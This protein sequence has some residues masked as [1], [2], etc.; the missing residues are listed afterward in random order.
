MR[1][2]TGALLI[3]ILFLTGCGSSKSGIKKSNYDRHLITLEEIERTTGS[4]AYDL[5]LKLRPFWIRGRGPRSINRNTEA[6]YPMIYLN[7]QK[8][9][10]ID[11]LSEITNTNITEIKFLSPSD[12][13][14]RYGVN[15]GGGA[16]LIKI[17]YE[18]K[19]ASEQ[20]KF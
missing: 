17:F 11:T 4:T 1:I 15:H 14:I 6:Q 18:R 16:I 19:N 20:D 7:G 2:F 3:A 5:I 8:F 12:A 9:G 13:T 10:N